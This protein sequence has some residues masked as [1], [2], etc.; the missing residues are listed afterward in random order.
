MSK[1]AKIIL[2]VI[3]VTSQGAV[4]MASSLTLMPQPQYFTS[5]TTHFSLT[6][7]LPYWSDSN[8]ERVN[9]GISRLNSRLKKLDSKIQLIAAKSKESAKLVLLISS[10][11]ID[12]NPQLYDDESYSLTVNP[13]TMQLTAANDLGIIR[14]LET[15]TQLIYANSNNQIQSI[16]ILD[17]PQYP[18]RGLLI[19]SA[20][21]FMPIETIKRQL[22]GMAAAKLN[23]F[24]W[25]LT[26]DQGWRFESQTYP[27]LHTVA[28]DGDFYTKV[29]MRDVV[30]YASLLGIRVV[31]ELD[32][33][34]HASAIARAYPELMTLDKQ[35]KRESH[36]GVFKPLL[37]PSNPEVFVFIESLIGEFAEIF[38]DPYFHIGGD[39]IDPSHWQNSQ[40][41]QDYMKKHNIKNAQGLHTHF[42]GRV[43]ELLKQRGKVMM[44]WDEVFTPGLPKDTVVQSWRGFDSLAA[45]TEAGHMGLLSTGFYIDQAQPTGYHY[46]NN[47]RPDIDSTP[48]PAPEANTLE[49]NF[50]MPRLKGSDVA[51]K[52]VL[53]SPLHTS[54]FGFLKLNNNT[55]KAVH[56]VEHTK[57]S[58]TIS[59]DTWMG[60]FAARF[61][62]S[63]NGI[64][65]GSILV[66]NT[67]YEMEQI[68]VQKT[69][70]SDYPQ[71]HQ[72]TM[73]YSNLLG[74]E[75]TIWSELVT[76]NNID[77]RIW[78]RLF[79]I[80]ERFWSSSALID[81]TSMY[82]RLL[83]IEKYADKIVGL[84]HIKQQRI[85]LANLLEDPTLLPHL[86]HVSQMLE[87]AQ[88]Y[89]RHHIKYQQN[90]YH[91]QAPLDQWADFLAVESLTL[92]QLSLGWHKALTEVQ[93]TELEQEIK[94]WQASTN[95]LLEQISSEPKLRFHQAMLT[96]IAKELALGI[97]LI[98]T[99][100]RKPGSELAHE[101]SVNFGEIIFALGHTLNTLNRMCHR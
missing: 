94:H 47:L 79:A 38:P 8:N 45:I 58:L 30:E 4:S 65:S 20:R 72:S 55:F 100:Q 54:T 6:P 53:E 5:E 1:F 22:D 7:A 9:K 70:G 69:R 66:G 50:V 62:M 60:P 85:G 43:N 90:L 78:P 3:F 48:A 42:N 36:W 13:Q 83:K 91:Q 71:Q 87:P 61:N 89:T 56:I 40:N 63:G 59:L 10:Q 12:R 77:I 28:S 86:L 52:L 16:K 81:E 37:D 95:K 84:S 74:G 24:H 88:Y 33:P 34:G 17:K 73:K 39:E 29:Q 64:A 15:L 21:H 93:L 41:V 19:D 101:F 46:R 14:G 97:Q 99:C 31:P 57:S 68:S 11:A 76:E 80:G 92:K 75:A 35:Y 23:V 49:V 25:H 27:K 44:G 82:Q 32:V 67:P 26:D 2:L 96:A 98:D 51:G 18:W